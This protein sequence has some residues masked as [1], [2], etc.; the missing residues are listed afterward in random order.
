MLIVGRHHIRVP[1]EHEA[2]FGLRANAGEQVCLAPAVVVHDLRSDAV[3]REVVADPVDQRQVGVARNRRKG[4]Q[5][6]EDFNGAEAG[7]DDSQA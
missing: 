7:H 1:G 5:A 3:I 2:A 6:F 4:D